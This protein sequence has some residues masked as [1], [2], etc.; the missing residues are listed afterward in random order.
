LRFAADEER[1]YQ[2]LAGFVLE[3]LGHIPAEG[4]TFTA[5]GWDFEII[6]MDRPRIDKV[7][8]RPAKQAS[9]STA[10]QNG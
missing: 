1:G 7:L 9:P 6:D 8:L 3:H 2:T 4:E 10:P 5:L